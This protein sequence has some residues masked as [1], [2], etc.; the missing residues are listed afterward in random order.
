MDPQKSPALFGI[1]KNSDDENVAESR[2][3]LLCDKYEGATDGLS[4][5]FLKSKNVHPKAFRARS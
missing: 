1:A 4:C 3:S 5:D 2:F